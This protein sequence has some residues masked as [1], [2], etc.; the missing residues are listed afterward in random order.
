MRF[1]MSASPDGDRIAITIGWAARL[2]RRRTHS[3]LPAV[4]ACL[5]FFFAFSPSVR[6]NIRTKILHTERRCRHE[7]AFCLLA[8]G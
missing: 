2:D 4:Q 5:P 3:T 7:E 8:E 6:D 1:R